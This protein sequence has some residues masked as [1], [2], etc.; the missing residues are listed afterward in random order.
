ML[1]S[2]SVRQQRLPETTGD[3]VEVKNHLTQA[4]LNEPFN[5]KNQNMLKDALI[6]L[7]E[8]V[9]LPQFKTKSNQICCVLG[10]LSS[11][12]TFL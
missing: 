11:V 3:L 9:S 6:L 7:P 4:N 2:H 1:V 12:F 8:G 5:T 10:F